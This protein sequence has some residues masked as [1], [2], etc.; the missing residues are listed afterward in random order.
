MYTISLN[1][2]AFFYFTKLKRNMRKR[3]N[4]S[5]SE[6]FKEKTEYILKKSAKTS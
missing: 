6:R 4:K 5:I 1:I 2:A 3:E